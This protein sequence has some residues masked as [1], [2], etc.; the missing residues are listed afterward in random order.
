[1]RPRTLKRMVQMTTRQR[2]KYLARW[3]AVAL[4]ILSVAFAIV[5]Y[6]NHWDWL[7]NDDRAEKV[8][9]RFDLSYAD[10]ASL[11]VQRGDPEWVPVLN[12]I[13]EYSPHRSELPVDRLPMTVARYPAIISA[14]AADAEWTAPTTPIVLFY[15]KWPDP[16]S[17]D[18][19]RGQDAFVVGT[20]GDLHDW[21]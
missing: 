17:G 5:S 9:E 4:S 8:A 15:R 6:N 1:M 10:D 2:I 20:I 12:V 21:V 11:P 7:L 18:Y 16:G 13:E 3:T 19:K 14:R